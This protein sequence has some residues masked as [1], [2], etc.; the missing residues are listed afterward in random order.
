M[1]NSLE[2]FN[3]M[4]KKYFTDRKCYKVGKCIVFILIYW[5]YLLNLML[6]KLKTILTYFTLF[7]DDECIGVLCHLLLNQFIHRESLNRK[8]GRK[9]FMLKLAP[10]WDV[11][12]KNSKLEDG[13]RYLITK[14]VIAWKFVNSGNTKKVKVG[15]VRYVNS[16]MNRM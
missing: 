14:D 13:N 9:T 1:N 5:F 2:S 12:Y 16:T 15:R 8:H 6:N 11:L 3:A 4:L 10:T 7:H